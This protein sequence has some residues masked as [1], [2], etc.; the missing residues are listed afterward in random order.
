M[1]RRS[2]ARR[3][4]RQNDDDHQNWFEVHFSLLYHKHEVN[5]EKLVL[6]EKGHTYGKLVRCVTVGSERVGIQTEGDG[7]VSVLLI[8][9]S[10]TNTY[11]LGILTADSDSF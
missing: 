7:N 4:H 9:S 1:T 11:V 3:H 8:N 6:Y 2:N 5:S 10:E